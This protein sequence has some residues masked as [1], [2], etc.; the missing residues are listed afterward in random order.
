MSRSKLAAYH[1]GVR[2]EPHADGDYLGYVKEF[3]KLNARASSEK[4]ALWEIKVLTREFVKDRKM[5]GL[6]IP[7][8]GEILE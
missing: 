3:R 5:F 8:P 2:Y 7:E 1:Y 6:P 4:K